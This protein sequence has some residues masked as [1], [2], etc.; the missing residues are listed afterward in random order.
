MTLE[1]LAPEGAT[2]ESA[3][4]VI[5][6]ALSVRDR[7]ARAHDRSYFD[8]FDGL[9][10]GHGA[11]LVHERGELVLVRNGV[12]RARAASRRPRRPF[13]VTDLSEGP[14]RDALAGLVGVR[15]LLPTARIHTRERALDLLDDERKTV[16]R[17]VLCAAAEAPGANGSADL[18]RPRLSLEG[19]RGYDQE[20]QALMRTLLGELGFV[21]AGRSMIDD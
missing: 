6:S 8:T 15:A 14:L 21:A 9:L 19:V 11:V 18:R 5:A 16:A 7:A 2:L 12:E 10:H 13:L 17:G 20:L 4:A 3:A 1:L